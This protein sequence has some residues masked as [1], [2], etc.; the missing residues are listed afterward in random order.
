[1]RL[2]ILQHHLVVL[3]VGG[4]EKERLVVAARVI[5]IRLG[6]PR[7]FVRVVDVVLGIVR[8]P[9]PTFAVARVGVVKAIP[10]L[11]LD[12][13]LSFF[14]PLQHVREPLPVLFVPLPEIVLAR[15]GSRR[16]A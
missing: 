4:R 3:L 12:D 11:D 5:G 8:V 10:H 6:K 13:D 14:G 2:L 9:L 15:S 16:N 1:M 7:F